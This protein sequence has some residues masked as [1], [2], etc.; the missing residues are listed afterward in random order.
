M[1]EALK[2][3]YNHDQIVKIEIFPQEE[4]SLYLTKGKKSFFNP[5]G[6]LWRY[7]T[8]SEGYTKEQILKDK[9]YFFMNGKF[10]IYPRVRISFTNGSTVYLPFKTLEQA[11]KFAEDQPHFS[12]WNKSLTINDSGT[13]KVERLK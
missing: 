11:I 13:Y 1:T 12:G 5:Y 6:G 3:I 8:L 2:T 10:Y 9:K 7:N 4:S